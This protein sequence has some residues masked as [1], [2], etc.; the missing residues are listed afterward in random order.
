[1]PAVIPDT[2]PPATEALLLLML[3]V[4]VPVELNNV[5]IPPSQTVAVPVITAGTGSTVRVN[6][7]EQPVEII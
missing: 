2:S 4:P 7:F 6:I 3:H 5:V 1:M